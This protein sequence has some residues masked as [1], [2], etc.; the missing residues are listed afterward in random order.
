MPLQG[1]SALDGTHNAARK[2]LDSFHYLADTISSVSYGPSK[3]LGE[4]TADQ[5]NPSYWVPNSDIIVS[6]YLILFVLLDAYKLF[7][8]W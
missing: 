3:V 7:N 4:W 6:C 8:I 5:I 1:V 2:V